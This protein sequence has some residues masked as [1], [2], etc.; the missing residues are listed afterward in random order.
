M[1]WPGVIKEAVGDDKI[2]SLMLCHAN[3]MEGAAWLDGFS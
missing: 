1:P 2:A 3:D